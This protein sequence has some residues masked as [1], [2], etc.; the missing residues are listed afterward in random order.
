MKKKHLKSHHPTTIMLFNSV[1][2]FPVSVHSHTFLHSCN[3]GVCAKWRP[4]T[5]L[6]HVLSYKYLFFSII[7][8][9][10]IKG[11]YAIKWLCHN[12]FNCASTIKRLDCSLFFSIRQI[13]SNVFFHL[14][15]TYFLFQSYPQDKF[16]TEYEHLYGN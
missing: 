10:I 4:F 15:S 3:K 1:Y 16:L 9:I 5:H 13:V 7:I 2:S 12:F 6:L 8:L 14:H 11:Q